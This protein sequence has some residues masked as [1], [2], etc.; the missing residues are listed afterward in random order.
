MSNEREERLRQW[1][2]DADDLYSASCWAE[3][4]D[5]DVLANHR[6]IARLRLLVE[7]LLTAR[8]LSPTTPP[9]FVVLVD[10]D[11]YDGIYKYA[12][13]TGAICQIAFTEINGWYV[14]LAPSYF[15]DDEAEHGVY[16]LH[17]SN[18]VEVC[19]ALGIDPERLL[20]A[21]ITA[22]D[23]ERTIARAERGM[24]DFD[25]AETI[26]E[27]AEAEGWADDLYDTPPP[28][29]AAEGGAS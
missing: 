18:G 27:R 14:D 22:E 9:A 6:E 29:P 28:P 23:A 20:P 21:A 13:A 10:S 1:L 4:I 16:R 25:P 19:A 8:R 5:A 11:E 26:M 24:V 12:V 2:T 17:I 3:Q 7:Q 15:A